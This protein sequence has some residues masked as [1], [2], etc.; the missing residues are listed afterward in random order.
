M[1]D[2]PYTKDARLCD[3]DGIVRQGVMH[4]GTD[5]PCTGHAHFGGD[6]IRC[7][8]PA[9]VP[10]LGPCQCCEN[11][12]AVGVAAVPGA[13]MSIA[14]G[15][16]CL[17]Q[18]ASPLWVADFNVAMCVPPTDVG[19]H[20]VG[21]WY[22]EIVVYAEGEYVRL[23]TMPLYVVKCAHCEGTEEIEGEPCQMCLHGKVVSIIAEDA[24]D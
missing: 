13:P 1:T 7:T 18:G 20:H 6:H 9:H 14:W 3:D 4:H 16:E 5:Y 21:D 17:R 11:E 23:D 19:W 24:G 2:D 10:D 15:K 12:P 8:S 22:R